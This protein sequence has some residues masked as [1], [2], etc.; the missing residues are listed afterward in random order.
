MVNAT[1]VIWLTDI[2]TEGHAKDCRYIQLFAQLMNTPFRWCAGI[3][4]DENRAY[5]GRSLRKKF[6][7]HTGSDMA[8]SPED[9][10]ASVLEVLVALA[11][12]IESDIMHDSEYGDRTSLW[13]KYMIE[14]LG[15]DQCTDVAYDASYV[16]A[17]LERFMDRQY[18]PCGRGGLFTTADPTV[19]MPTIEIWQQ[20]QIWL[21]HDIM[22]R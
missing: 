15:L 4:L 14:S 21:L 16:N 13:F 18:E 2:A 22:K 17:T 9:A 7:K 1:Y 10:P 6:C 8:L 19:L 5:D 20:A 12:R 11:M 3:P